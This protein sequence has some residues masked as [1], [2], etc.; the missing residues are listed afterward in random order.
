MKIFLLYSYRSLI[1]S[2]RPNHTI[3]IMIDDINNNI[4][5]PKG[6]ER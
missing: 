6:G 3:A 2:L 1:H 4:L 5:T